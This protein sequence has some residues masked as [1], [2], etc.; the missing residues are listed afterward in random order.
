[1]PTLDCLY[2]AI[3]S[4]NDCCVDLVPINYTLMQD[5]QNVFEHGEDISCRN[6]PSSPSKSLK[7]DVHYGT[8]IW[9]TGA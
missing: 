5:H 2:F 8:Q 6:G 1:M 7:Y 4:M 9:Y 3:N